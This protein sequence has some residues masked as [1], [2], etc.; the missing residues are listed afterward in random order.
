MEEIHI[1]FRV[2]ETELVEMLQLPACEFTAH[3]AYKNAEMNLKSTT[4]NGFNL[5][6]INSVME[7]CGVRLTWLDCNLLYTT[8]ESVLLN[9]AM[10]SIQCA[11]TCLI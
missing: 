1:K 6:K 11:L 3:Y 2:G 9:L 4:T 5:R 8:L 10:G 7:S